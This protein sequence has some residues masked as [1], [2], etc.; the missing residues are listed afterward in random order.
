MANPL[1]R[2]SVLSLRQAQHIRLQRQYSPLKSPLRTFQ[3]SCLQRQD[4]DDR[5]GIL[6]VPKEFKFDYDALEPEAK[7]DYDSLSPEDKIAFQNDART[8]W[9]HFNSPDVQSEL[10]AHVSQL[11]YELSQENPRPRPTP[12]R[13]QPG[14]FAMGEDD[15][16]G[17]GE[18]GDFNGDDISSLAH[19][20]LEQH[21]EIR[22]YARIAAW[23]M[24]LL[25]STLMSIKLG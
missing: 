16:Q 13:I 20:E 1:L 22:E 18:D 24:P 19:G 9:E 12:E 17:T 23:E 5:D 8:T 6:K 3:S 2:L 15:E 25:S 14:F 21:R 11:A 10:N 4:D 7:A